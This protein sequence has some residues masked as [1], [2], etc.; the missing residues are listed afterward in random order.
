MDIKTYPS[1]ETQSIRFSVDINLP[2][3]I[4]RGKISQQSLIDL[5]NSVRRMAQQWINME[6][7]IQGPAEKDNVEVE[8]EE[9]N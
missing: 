2:T 3:D 7:S 8:I 9:L 1:G 4:D 5:E 6:R